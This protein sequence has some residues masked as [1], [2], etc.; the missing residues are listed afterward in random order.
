MNHYKLDYKE[1]LSEVFWMTIEKYS[2]I[3]KISQ[4]ILELKKSDNNLKN[5]I[6]KLSTESDLTMC[7]N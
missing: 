1:L 5:L 6:H 3:E 2:E 7:D 4:K